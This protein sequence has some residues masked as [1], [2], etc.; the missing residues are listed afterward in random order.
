M[1]GNE[2]VFIRVRVQQGKPSNMIYMEC[3]YKEVV[4]VTPEWVVLSVLIRTL[5]EGSPLYMA[6]KVKNY[7]SIWI[8][9]WL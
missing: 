2:R 7:L 6:A 1:Q 3:Q 8:S 9:S 5:N 4:P